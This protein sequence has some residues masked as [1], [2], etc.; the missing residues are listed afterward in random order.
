MSEETNLPVKRE[1]GDC[2]MCCKL[3]GVASI[4]K[5]RGV[6]CPSCDTKKGHLG[7]KVHTPEQ[8]PAECQSF[9]CLWLQS[10]NEEIPDHWRPDRIK[11]ILT[12]T[13]PV[14]GQVQSVVAW[15]D[16]AYP[17]A[18][19]LPEVTN[20]LSNMVTQQGIDVTAI[21]GTKTL[22]LGARKDNHELVIADPEVH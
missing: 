1:C 9:E 10:T 2:K 12:A 3:L 8:Q 15:V 13:R 7:C 20:T 6:W 14:E 22:K 18:L 17:R 4:K 5:P 19:R 11:V 16:P 21:C